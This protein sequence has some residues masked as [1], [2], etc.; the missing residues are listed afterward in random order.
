MV[1]YSRLCIAIGE[2]GN[3]FTRREKFGSHNRDYIS[4]SIAEVKELFS[5]ERKRL[6]ISQ[7]YS[8]G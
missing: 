1:H 8:L 6:G 5:R 2:A 3:R 4:E 7:R